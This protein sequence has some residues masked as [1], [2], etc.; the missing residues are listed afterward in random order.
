MSSTN[1][2][3]NR[4]GL[5]RYYTPDDLARAL[6]STLHIPSSALVLEP[7]VGGGAFVNAVRQVA[8]A[9]IF[10]IDVDPAAPGLDNTTKRRFTA[11]RVF[12]GDFLSHQFTVGDLAPYDGFDYI[13]GNPPFNDAEA[14]VRRARALVKPGGTVAFLLRL[15]F[16]E[17]AKRK[18]FWFA[19]R[20][21]CVTV[22]V[23][24]PSFTGGGTD[25]CPYGWF[26]WHHSRF[27]TTLDWLSWKAFARRTNKAAL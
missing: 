21:A 15:A 27:D 14:H 7:S 17:G 6:V 9:N 2:G 12:I 13:V 22:L 23:E 10:A 24:G 20:P 8:G 4:A 19:H 26:V 1:R 25:S 16:L 18:A 3:A 5:D 11:G